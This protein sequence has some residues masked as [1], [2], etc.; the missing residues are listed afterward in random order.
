MNVNK[1]KRTKSFNFLLPM[2][3]GIGSTIKD[4]PG[5]LNCYLND[6]QRKAEDS[7][8]VL[9]DF[10]GSVAFGKFEESLTKHKYYV[11][12]YDPTDK[13]V[14]FVFGVPDWKNYDLFLDGKYS[15]MSET[16][17]KHI[18]QFLDPKIE[19]GPIKEILYKSDERKKRLE[20]E[21]D[22]KIPSHLDLYDPPSL[23][24]ETFDVDEFK[25]QIQ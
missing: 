13:H 1:V 16:Y 17:K 2:I 3:G 4:F 6:I 18:L 9:F 14:M 10:D 24:E 15:K 22:I 12:A 11:E 21:Y 25:K 7:I 19:T 8:F 23:R 5:V 20:K